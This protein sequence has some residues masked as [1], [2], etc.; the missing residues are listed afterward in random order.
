MA[1]PARSRVRQR[2]SKQQ[3]LGVCGAMVRAMHPAAAIRFA[4]TS[5][6][7]AAPADVTWLFLL[8][9]RRATRS[10][11]SVT[12]TVAGTRC[13]RRCSQTGGAG[14]GSRSNA[15]CSRQPVCRLDRRWRSRWRPLP[16]NP[17]RWCRTTCVQRWPRSRPRVRPGTT[18]PP[19]RGASGSS[20]W[21]PAKGPK[22]GASASPPHA[23]C[24][25]RASGVRA[26]SIA[27][28]RT[29]T[30]WRHPR[31]K[32]A[33]AG[34]PV[35]E[36]PPSISQNAYMRHTSAHLYSGAVPPKRF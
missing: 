33:E 7:P 17:R 28:A 25:P 22:R 20:G 16:K 6:Q 11:V 34:G 4:A 24:W 35:R 23:P 15:P 18:S 36:W 12:G 26:V 2:G 29:A 27:W 5:L 13:R 19:W 30:R 14:I 3:N 8:L 1:L 10:M 21:C 31:Q 32:R 9:Q